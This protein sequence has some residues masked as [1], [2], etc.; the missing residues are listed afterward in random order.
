MLLSSVAERVYWFARY[1]ER[2]ENTVRLV[3]T[4]RRA[5]HGVFTFH[6]AHRDVQHT[7][8]G[9]GAQYRRRADECATTSRRALREGLRRRATAF[10]RALPWKSAG[11]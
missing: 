7:L 5:V 4:G 1:V 9:P 2:V 3:L 6:C 11:G 10:R 8:T